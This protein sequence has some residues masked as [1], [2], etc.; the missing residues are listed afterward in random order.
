MY[1]GGIHFD[2]STRSSVRSG[3]IIPNTKAS[4]GPVLPTT[5]FKDASQLNQL[6]QQCSAWPME[7]DHG[8]SSTIPRENRRNVFNTVSPQCPKATIATLPLQLPP[9]TVLREAFAGGITRST[10]VEPL[11]RTNSRNRPYQN[12]MISPS[13][14]ILWRCSAALLMFKLILQIRS[15]LLRHP[16]QQCTHCSISLSWHV[17]ESC[18]NMRHCSSGIFCNTFVQ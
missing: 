11:Q 1:A 8:A 6:A 2:H 14:A 16:H 18:P 3:L 15:M 12:A 4:I 17:S 5:V 10:C 7:S 13:V 9:Q